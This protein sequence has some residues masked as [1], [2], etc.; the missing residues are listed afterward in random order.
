[1]LYATNADAPKESGGRL[2]AAVWISISF[3]GQILDMPSWVVGR[4]PG[5]SRS[6]LDR[7]Q[8]VDAMT[9]QLHC[10]SPMG[11]ILHLAAPGSSFEQ[12]FPIKLAGRRVICDDGCPVA[13]LLSCLLRFPRD[14][15]LIGFEVSFFVKY[16]QV[17]EMLR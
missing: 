9:I 4:G 5:T 10:V 1:M 12:Y 8:S 2:Q 3:G 11:S 17:M 14:V 15:A 7:A 16:A 6:D 13:R